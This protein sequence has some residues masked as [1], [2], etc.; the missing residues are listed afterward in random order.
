MYLVCVLKSFLL[1]KR[2]SEYKISFF[3]FNKLETEGITWL[4]IFMVR[5]DVP[6]ITW[7]NT[8]SLQSHNSLMYISLEL[9]PTHCN[10]IVFWCTLVQCCAFQDFLVQYKFSCK[11]VFACFFLTWISVQVLVCQ[12]LYFY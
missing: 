12:K 9:L 5:F 6:S 1:C 11:F 10:R 4:T 8:A 2:T 7:Q 3:F